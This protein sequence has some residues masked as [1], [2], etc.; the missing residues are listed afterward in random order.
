M[1]ETFFSLGQV[2]SHLQIDKF[3]VFR[4]VAQNEMPAIK[5]GNNGVSKDSRSKSSACGTQTS[6]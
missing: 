6:A 2:A 4:L 1:Q 3:T 5:I